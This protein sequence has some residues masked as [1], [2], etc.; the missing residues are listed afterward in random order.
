MDLEYSA[1]EKS[2]RDDIRTFISQNL[3]KEV[4]AKVLG[5]KRLSREDYL[6]WHRILHTRGR[7]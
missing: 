4:A 7:S 6:G 3:A 5:Y 2:F 1:A